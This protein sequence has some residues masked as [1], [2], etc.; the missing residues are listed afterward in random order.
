MI[1]RMRR[2]VIIAAMLA[3][4]AVIIMLAVLVNI[5]NYAVITGRVD[6]TINGISTFES[7][8]PDRDE[9]PE[10][11]REPFK[12]HPDEESNYMTRFFVVRYNESGEM[13][14]VS[15]EFVASIDDTKAE[16]FGQRALS[17]KSDRGYIEEYRFLKQSV[18]NS[19]VII[20]LNAIRERQYIKSLLIMT[21]VISLVSLLLVFVLVVI[22]SRRAIK[23]FANNITRQKQFITDASH[24]LKTPLTSIRT[25]LDVIELEHGS[26]EWTD[27]IKRQTGRMTKLVSEMVAL[28]RLDEEHPLPTKEQF[29]L[30]NAAWEIAD[31]YVTQAKAV[32]KTFDVDIEENLSLN[33][34]KSTVQQLLSVLLDNAIKYSDPNGS[35]R[36]TV[37]KKRNKV[38]MEVYNTCHY[39]TPPDTEKLFDRFYRPD[40]SRSTETGGNGVGLAIAKAVVEAHGGTISAE[41]PDGKSMLIKVKI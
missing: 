24:E 33:G 25:S 21:I 38:R 1:K 32:D 6:E 35:I 37:K 13:D 19:T 10:P 36:F 39:D 3:F 40:G 4:S 41:C 14:S 2:R 28:S 31:I 30:S 26:D 20:F 8:M 5:V 11:R 22:L 9:P 17:K 7:R 27:N 18:G 23:P 29:S 16:T 34:D 12:V 15:T